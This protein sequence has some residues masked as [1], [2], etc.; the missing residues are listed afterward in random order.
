MLQTS[1]LHAGR[2]V[3]V[4]PCPTALLPLRPTASL[5][6][7]DRCSNL[8][9]AALRAPDNTTQHAAR[10]AALRPLHA[11][12]DSDSVEEV[13]ADGNAPAKPSAAETA[14]TVLDIAAHGTLATINE[15]GKPLGT[16]ALFGSL[17]HSP[18]PETYILLFA[19]IHRGRSCL[20]SHFSAF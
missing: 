5:S 10:C 18:R 15:D 16:C 20:S 4:L 3:A 13:D 14:R 7:R 12:P 9:L 11:L 6:S 8:P 1:C 17:D 2:A 19:C